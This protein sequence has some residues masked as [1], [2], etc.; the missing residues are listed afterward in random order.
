MEFLVTTK[1]KLIVHILLNELVDI[2]VNKVHKIEGNDRLVDDYINNNKFIISKNQTKFDLK[3]EQFSEHNV[4]E[5][6]N[7]NSVAW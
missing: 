5:N 1:T 7:K 3:N 6:K 2:K 4:R